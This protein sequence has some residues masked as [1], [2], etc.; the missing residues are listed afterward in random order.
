MSMTLKE[1]IC[2]YLQR[3]DDQ[4]VLHLCGKLFQQFLVDQFHRVEMERLNYLQ[5][6]QSEIRA[7]L[8]QGLAD[9]FRNGGNVRNVGRRVVLPSSFVGGPRYMNQV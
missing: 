5:T 1:Y 4:N 7:E 8:Y 2:Y 3:R 6:H 9:H